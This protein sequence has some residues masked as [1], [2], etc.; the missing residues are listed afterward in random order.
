MF[1]WA[2][3]DLLHYLHSVE[4]TVPQCDS[5][6]S[7]SRRQHLFKYANHSTHVVYIVGRH[8]VVFD[9]NIMFR[10]CEGRRPLL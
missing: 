7:I 3:S 6:E 9:K 4:K 2:D 10:Q 1:F 5:G 8:T